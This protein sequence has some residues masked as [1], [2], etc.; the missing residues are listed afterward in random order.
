MVALA[1]KNSLVSPQSVGQF[2]LEYLSITLEHSL[3]YIMIPV[4]CLFS[5]Q[6]T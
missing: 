4:S 2:C 6:L 1:E 3:I 5:S